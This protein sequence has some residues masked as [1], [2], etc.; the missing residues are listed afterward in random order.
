[1]IARLAARLAARLTLSLA[2]A[3]ADWPLAAATLGV[4]ALTILAIE[5]Q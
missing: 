4:L 3:R 5:V 1:M 2:E